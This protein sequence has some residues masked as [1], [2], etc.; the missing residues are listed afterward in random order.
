MK[1]SASADA[2]QRLVDTIAQHGNTTIAEEDALLLLIVDQFW[3]MNMKVLPQRPRSGWTKPY[4]SLL[5]SLA[6][7][8]QVSLM[9]IV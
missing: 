3:P 6:E 7:H 2:L 5:R 8:G 4:L 9:D 1:A